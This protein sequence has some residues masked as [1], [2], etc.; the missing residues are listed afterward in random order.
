MERQ[1]HTDRHT[2]KQAFLRVAM[3][4]SASCDIIEVAKSAP[5][6]RSGDFLCGHD[7]YGTRYIE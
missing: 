3:V 1:G 4:S 7:L 2:L 6:I 5:K